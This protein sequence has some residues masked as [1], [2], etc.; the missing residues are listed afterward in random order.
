MLSFFDWMCF[1]YCRSDY[2]FNP[3]Y[4][5]WER[6]QRQMREMNGKSPEEAAM[7]KLIGAVMFMMFFGMWVQYSV[8]K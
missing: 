3:G 8:Y 2:E 5:E 4:A 7:F 1:F 6:Y